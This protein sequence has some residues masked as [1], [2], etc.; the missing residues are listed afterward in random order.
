MSF[1]KILYGVF[2]AFL[3]ASCS[4]SATPPVIYATYDPFLPIPAGTQVFTDADPQV[5]VTGTRKPTP[6]RAALTVS[7]IA[8][9]AANQVQGTPTPDRGRFLPTPR[10]DAEQYEVLPGDTLMSIADQFGISM[11]TLMQSNNLI[12]PNFLTVGMQL[13][14]PAAVPGDVGTSFKII[15]DSELVYGPASI[16]FD[17]GEFIQ[18]QHGYLASYSQ[19]V[20]GQFLNGNEIILLVAQNYS[21]N[22]RLLLALLEYQSGWVTNPQPANI[23]Y[24]MGMLDVNHIGLYRQ[25]TWAANTLNRGYYLW[26][27]NALS[28]WALADSTVILIDPA[29]NAGTASVQYFFS[30]L[31]DRTAWE[32][33]V[34]GTGFLLTYFVFFGNPFNFA[35]EPLVSTSIT[36]PPMTLPFEK[37]QSWYFTGGPHGGWDSG[38][39]WGALDFAPPGESGCSTNPHWV[40]AMADGLVVR[41]DDG[42]VMQDLDNDGYEQTGWVI[43]YMHVAAEDRIQ[44]GQYIF[45]SE[46]VG[47]ASCEGGFSNAT[48]VHIARKFNG[49]WIPAD[50]KRPF[51][52]D[53]WTSSG[54][55]IEYDGFLSKGPQTIEAL[56]RADPLN[57]ITR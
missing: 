5:S 9:D 27:A 57:L 35:I 12:D 54:N 15:P 26:K 2:S 48:H 11:E 33:D 4:S 6:A 34:N 16:Y 1:Q 43:F 46:R 21:V 40:T 39:A 17:I 32:K 29:I 37:G 55:G 47:H 42:A 51:V 14:V 45:A 3:L 44:T 8:E 25:L 31:D 7:P 36:Q 19:D 24:P 52:I 41:S 28:T 50:G 49:E 53:G 13:N 22:P 30:Q 10:L 18:S 38:S 20:N 23:D 56:D